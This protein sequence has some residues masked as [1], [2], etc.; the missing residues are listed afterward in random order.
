M[1]DGVEVFVTDGGQDFKPNAVIFE[2]PWRNVMRATINRDFVASRYQ[3]GREMLCEC[4]KAAVAG[5]YTSGS[6][7]GYAHDLRTLLTPAGS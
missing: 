3:S 2:L 5:G 7:N 6:E 1:Y 4:F